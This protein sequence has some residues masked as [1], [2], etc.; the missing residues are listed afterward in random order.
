MFIRKK[1]TGPYYYLQVVKTVRVG[2]VVRQKLVG[3]LGRMDKLKKTGELKGLLKSLRQYAT[4]LH[5]PEEA[6]Q[7][8][9]GQQDVSVS[10]VEAVDTVDVADNRKRIF[11]VDDDPQL[12]INMR[13]DFRKYESDYNVICCEDA[14]DALLMIGV[15]LPDLILLDIYMKGLDGFELCRRLRRMPHLSHTKIV[16]MTGFPAEEDE[17]KIYEAGAREYWIKPVRAEFI[18][19]WIVEHPGRIDKPAV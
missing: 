4:K 10:E 17:K 14:I 13:R 12:L 1:H 6:W 3:T 5:G 11:I 15:D 19:K 9:E 18:I 7:Q 16:A 2:E 8:E